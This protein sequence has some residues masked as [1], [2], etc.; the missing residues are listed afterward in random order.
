[1]KFTKLISAFLWVASG[2]LFSW[3]HAAVVDGTPAYSKQTDT[4]LY[5]WRTSSGDWQTRLVSGGAD[6]QVFVGTFEASQSISVIKQISIESD[7]IV[8]PAGTDSLLTGLIVNQGGIDGLVLSLAVGSDLCLRDTGNTGTV[9]YL[10]KDAV[11]A[12]PPVDLSGSGACDEE[13]LPPP[14]PPPPV[15]ET[16]KYTP[17]HYTFL[18]R[19]NGS[20]TAMRNSVRPGVV[21]I[22][23]RYTWRSLEP[24]LGQYDFSEIESDLQLVASQGMQL[25]AMIEDKT[26]TEE[27]PLPKYLDSDQY[28]RANR[29]GGYTAVRW[30]PYVVTRLKALIS[31]LGQS[32]DAH[33]NFE[34]I[35]TQETAPSLD[36][37]ILDATGY[38]PEKYRDALIDVLSDATSSLPTSRIF[39]Y[40]N[41][42]PRNN[43]YLAEVASAV[44]SLGVVM[45]A[46]DVMPDNQPLV[47]HTYPLFDQFKGTMPMFGQVEQVCYRHL[48]DDTSYPTKYWTM[49]ELFDFGRDNMHLNYMFWVRVGKPN[50]SDSYSWYYALPVMANNPLINP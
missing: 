18:I 16:R 11:V 39:W 41:F 40:M 4:G 20:H 47:K 14:P 21:G 31:A 50:P 10:G 3:V 38:T 19:R 29:V 17:G 12:T 15:S 33:P 8:A 25:V 42:L 24:A 13:V 30:S 32:V 27:V 23:K 7:D 5:V 44:Q 22:V 2:L 43:G 45:G 37:P 34:G 35:A 6:K 26:F 1:M 9:V 46:P 49:Q 48:H 28:V 36:D